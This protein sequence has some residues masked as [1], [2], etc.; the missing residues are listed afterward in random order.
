[1]EGE[2]L[3]LLKCDLV[4]LKEIYRA[5]FGDEALKVAIRMGKKRREYINEIRRACKR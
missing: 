3:D 2:D 5:I 4:E 1:M